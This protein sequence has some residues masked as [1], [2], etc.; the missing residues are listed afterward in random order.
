MNVYNR[1][2]A[3]IQKQRIK[4]VWFRFLNS[5]YHMFYQY[6]LTI[7][8]WALQLMVMWKPTKNGKKFRENYGSFNL[9]WRNN[10]I[11]YFR[12]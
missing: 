9:Y 4:T 8:L 7:N 3:R 11:K 1:M 6:D 12:F 10:R 5:K 2:K